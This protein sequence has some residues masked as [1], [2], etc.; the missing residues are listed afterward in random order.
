MAGVS[1][2]VAVGTSN[3]I[4][5]SPTTERKATEPEKDGYCSEMAG[6]VGE[7]YAEKKVDLLAQLSYH[8]I[9]VSIFDGLT[10]T[11]IDRKARSII[12]S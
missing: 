1:H 5:G 9:P 10:E 11:E 2:A 3:F 8:N 12:F 6:C 4:Y 7:T